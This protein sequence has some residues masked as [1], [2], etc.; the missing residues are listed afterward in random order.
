MSYEKL[1]VLWP[2]DCFGQAGA[3]PTCSR[4][5]IGLGPLDD[6]D[7]PV[8]LRYSWQSWF[9]HWNACSRAT[10]KSTFKLSLMISAFIQCGTVTKISTYRESKQVPFVISLSWCL[11]LSFCAWET[12]TISAVGEESKP[13]LD[14]VW[15]CPNYTAAAWMTWHAW[16]VVD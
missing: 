12:F 4:L 2:A 11:S 6:H 15:K 3:M 16:Q 7:I 1:A 14:L 5:T 13:A 10:V 8:L 9:D